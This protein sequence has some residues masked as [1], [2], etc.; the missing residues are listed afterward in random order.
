MKSVL[1]IGG[2]LSAFGVVMAAPG[3]AFADTTAEAGW[4]KMTQCASIADDKARHSCTDDALRDAGLLE[5]KVSEKRK[6]FGLQNPA[7][8]PVA[9]PPVA[10]GAAAAGTATAAGTVAAPAP[11][12]PP[13]KKQR[14]QVEVTLAKVA[15]AGDKLVLTTTDGAVWHQVESGAVRQPPKQGETMKIETRSLGGFMCQPSRYVSFRCYRS[16]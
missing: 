7:P 10:T 3:L 14:E 5:S 1:R 15:Q 6:T 11:K 13:P 8:A 16:K 9:A 4:A 2:V 12:S